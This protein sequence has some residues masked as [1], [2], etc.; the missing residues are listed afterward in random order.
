MTKQQSLEGMESEIIPELTE[1]AQQYA[2]ARDDRMKCGKV[3]K[4]RKT[5]L[6]LLMHKYEL[7]SYEDHDEDPPV[8]VLLVKGEEKVKVRIQGEEEEDDE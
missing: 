7:E 4:E 8:T 1:A 5:A 6:I 2:D 3:E